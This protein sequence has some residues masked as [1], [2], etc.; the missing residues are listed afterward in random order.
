MTR[1]VDALEERGLVRRR[2][3]LR[4]RRHVQIHLTA[5]GHRKFEE[6]LPTVLWNIDRVVAGFSPDELDTLM[7]FLR[8]MR[9]NVYRVGGTSNVA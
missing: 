6:V 5:T 1:S 4:D 8:R 3:E 9:D 7:D 2:R